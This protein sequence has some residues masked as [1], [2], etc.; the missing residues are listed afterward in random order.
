MCFRSDDGSER[1][2]SSSSSTLSPASTEELR[3]ATW[4]VKA[5]RGCR[6]GLMLKNIAKTLSCV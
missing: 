1:D 6:F 2:E 4:G 3:K 5:N